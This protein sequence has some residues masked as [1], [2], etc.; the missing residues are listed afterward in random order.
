MVD[1]VRVL[2]ELVVMFG[3]WEAWFE[4]INSLLMD[5]FQPYPL[6]FR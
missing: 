4:E 3:A 1:H 2:V 6:D 5:D